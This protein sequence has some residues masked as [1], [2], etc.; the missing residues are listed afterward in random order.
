MN[1]ETKNLLVRWKS[2]EEDD[3]LRRAESTARVLWLAGLALS[4]FVAFGV[5]YGL[6]PAAVAG[7]SRGIWG[8]GTFH[9]LVCGDEA[10]GHDVRRRGDCHA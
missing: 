2:R 5:V 4:I 9:G 8:A 10:D 6:H 7:E 1:T 3:G